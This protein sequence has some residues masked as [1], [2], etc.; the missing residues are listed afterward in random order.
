MQIYGMFFIDEFVNEKY[1]FYIFTNL[2]L[3]TYKIHKSKERNGKDRVIN[4]KFE[5]ICNFYCIS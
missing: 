1:V 2:Q 5:F 3:D 4:W